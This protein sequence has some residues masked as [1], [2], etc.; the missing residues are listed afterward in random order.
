MKNRQIHETEIRGRE[1]REEKER[2][3]GRMKGKETGGIVGEAK[4]KK[5]AAFQA[6]STTPTT[7]VEGTCCWRSDC[8]VDKAIPA[9]RTCAVCI[10]CSPL[11]RTDLPSDK[12]DLHI[13]CWADSETPLQ[14][15]VREY[16]K[17]NTKSSVHGI[18]PFPRII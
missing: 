18:N 11:Y 17:Y 6:I 12:I 10:Q 1:Q 7:P 2:E 4:E 8:R 13:A 3:T 9:L 16:I 15:P 5:T 14:N